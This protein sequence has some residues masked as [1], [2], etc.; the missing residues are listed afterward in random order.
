MASHWEPLHPEAVQKQ[1]PARATVRAIS[2]DLP[3]DAE[4][5]EQTQHQGGVHIQ[6]HCTA[7]ADEPLL[8]ER[9]RFCEVLCTCG[10]SLLPCSSQI[11]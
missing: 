7:A 1:H 6:V 9:R 11:P 5:S 3:N 8:L 10:Q 2:P 4:T